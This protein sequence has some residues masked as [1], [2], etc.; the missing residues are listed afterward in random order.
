LPAFAAR[1]VTVAQ[2]EQQLTQLRTRP[3]LEASQQIA[4]LQLTE[5][6][7]TERLAQL[8]GSLPGDKSR[9]ALLVLADVS[10][11][12]APPNA[13]LPVNPAPAF[14]EQKRIMGQVIGYLAK[15]LPL[16][17]DFTATSATT[18][19]EDT[20]LL[21]APGGFIPYQP[22]HKV[23]NSSAE[24]IYKDGLE[25]EEVRAKNDPGV[26]GLSSWGIFGQ[27]L[28]TVLVDAARSKLAW[29]RWE[30]EP[31]GIRA[32]FAYSVPR[33][34]SQYQ[35]NYCC[36]AEQ[37]ASVSAIVHPFQ[38]ISAYHGEIAVDPGTG[39]IRRIVI[40]AELKPSDPVVKAGI[41]V[42]YAPVEIG[43]RTYICPVRSV[44]R[45]LAQTVQVNPIYHFALANQMQPLKNF[46]ND[47]RF[48]NYHMFRGDARMLAEES[49]P[50]P[51]SPALPP[52]GQPDPPA[53]Q[54]SAVAAAQPPE[55]IPAPAATP[56]PAPKPEEPE[57]AELSS[58]DFPDSPGA[59]Q[60]TG[61]TL[62]LNSRLVDVAVVALDKKGRPVTDL[63]PEEIE[64]YDNGRRQQ[65]SFFT[66]AGS[67]SETAPVATPQQPAPD[68]PQVVSN[69]GD[70]APHSPLNN[71]NTTVLLIDSS[72]VAFF[73]M[74]YA[75]SEMLRFLKT[76]PADE[77]V[78][79]YILQ[80]FGFQV[81]LEPTTDHERVAST[82]TKWMPTAQDLQNAQS[83]EQQNRQ[84]I[85]WVHS[86]G[87]LA[88]V[89]GNGENGAA[90]S[91][92]L[93]GQAATDA[94]KYSP[95]PKLRRLGET[96]GQDALDL[97]ARVGRH[98]AAIPGHKTLVW[99][100]SDNVLA[101]WTNSAVSREERGGQFL[102][103]LAMRARE[104]LN[105][106]H[107]SVYPLDVSQLEGG[108]ITADTRN[109]NIIPVGKSDRD[110]SFS[111]MG[112]M[113][114]NGRNGRDTARMQ[115]DTHTIQGAFRDLAEATGGHAFR[116]AGDIAAE[117]QQVVA[118]GR[119]AYLLSFHPD[120][121]ADD[122]Y[123]HIVVKSTRA[124]LT[125]RYRTGYLYA[126]E[127][128]TIK[129]RIRQAVWDAGDANGI[130]LS[131]RLAR[132]GNTTT[133]KLTVAA[134]DLALAQQAD[135]W[136][137]KLHIV[138]AVRDDST[139]KASL[140]GR[141]IEMR[142]KPATYQSSLR[143]GLAVDQP[144]AEAAHP[145]LIRVLVIDENSGRIGAVTLRIPTK[146]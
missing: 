58:E 138:V 96:T 100:A 133:A 132:D 99:A 3:D 115:Q 75:R 60:N 18:R 119:A 126:K 36:V 67:G 131:A 78:G 12:L 2:L 6:L 48:E 50:N 1:N 74:N 7:S 112:D 55:P 129:D 137:G 56:A 106:A 29:S 122:L 113:A 79:L 128:A 34:K 49:V 37:A 47:V 101:D 94:N 27:V 123:H 8:Q 85:D 19:F 93:S 70:L 134:T 103:P 35:V 86:N 52:L 145:Q 39:A 77:R 109:R 23:G 135:R 66:Q 130:G 57:I 97:L 104:T 62:R 38:Q 42:E 139:L 83:Q 54:P 31:D 5:R 76:V 92:N 98:L 121:P 4:G 46:V 111:E 108:G 17:P 72:S 116:R 120:A 53:T 61:F 89:N 136:T 21:Q 87:D 26:P 124:G 125:L 69:R 9:E 68:E 13:D 32:V 127:P 28:R 84:Q 25:R 105:E 144:I 64:I 81:L 43:G 82:L 140:T 14:D 88:Y 40:E 24:V 146:P 95:D 30:S 90:P 15:A 41:V 65:V 143:E 22:L 141:T 142:L 102:D 10:S 11:F 73:D 44:S 107:V 59:A 71:G 118:D 91:A 33:E 110:S 51:A 45:S 20:P 80:R 114:P 117:L 63:K 16:L